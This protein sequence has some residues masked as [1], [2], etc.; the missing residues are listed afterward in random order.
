[1]IVKYIYDSR[2]FFPKHSPF[3]PFLIL[4]RLAMLRFVFRKVLYMISWSFIFNKLCNWKQFVPTT[5]SITFRKTSSFVCSLSWMSSL[6]FW[7]FVSFV[8]SILYIQSSFFLNDAWIGKNMV[9]ECFVLGY[10]F[11]TE[12][13]SSIQLASHFSK[14]GFL[15][16]S[17]IVL[18]NPSANA[19]PFDV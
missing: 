19:R 12:I 6:N 13:V 16:R 10:C 11:V 15:L 1:M 9:E 4:I 5:G 14:T 17:L 7:Y 8:D 2:S 3:F 18:I